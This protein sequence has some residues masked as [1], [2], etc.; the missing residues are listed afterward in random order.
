MAQPFLDLALIVA[1]LLDQVAALKRIEEASGVSTAIDDIKAAAPV[2]YV[3]PIRDQVGSNV[4]ANAVSQQV[5]AQFGILL[6]IKNV[7][8]P[9]GAK[10]REA[11]TPVR[12]DVADALL[13]WQPGGS[14]DKCE[15]AA[16][17]LVQLANG[18]LWWMDEY[19]TRFEIRST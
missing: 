11:L 10:A 2:A 13:N 17:R 1:R 16:G 5:T 7:R 19:R 8:D 9:L 15:F 14:Y 3:I 6:G 12:S 18:V 4:L